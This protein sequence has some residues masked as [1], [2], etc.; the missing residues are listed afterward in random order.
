MS[1]TSTTALSTDF[2][3][4]GGVPRKNQDFAA[5]IL[6]TVA[7]SIVIPILALRYFRKSSRTSI[8]LRIA[9]FLPTRIATFVIRTIQA[10]GD[11]SEGLFVSEQI[12]LLCGFLLLLEPFSTLVKFNLYRH[13]TPEGKKHNL[14]RTLFL[15]RL[16]LLA[17]VGLGEYIGSRAQ[18]ALT[19]PG[20]ESTTLRKCRWAA[21]GIS[22]GVVVLS[23]G[24]AVYAQTLERR[25][26]VRTVY[27]SVLGICLLIPSIYKL[28][29]YA[30]PSSPTSS[31]GKAVFYL[32]FCLPEL[33][34]ALVY[35]SINL[36]QTFEI[37]EG[38]AK[39]EWNEKAIEGD[40]GG[41]YSSPYS[42]W[43]ALRAS[44]EMDRKES[45]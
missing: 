32:L 4:S 44:R 23:L 42:E 33:L 16:A 14:A 17:A 19:D 15:I 20:S 27:L 13:W 30:N 5:S 1:S 8:L 29:L 2:V 9:F 10:G 31:S 36:E 7:Y 39:E 38:T 34:A 18:D 40:I 41:S 45:V 11:E 21:G 35:L 12:L 22:L 28:A 37:K 24:L 25:S 6:F 3:L 26:Y 43:K